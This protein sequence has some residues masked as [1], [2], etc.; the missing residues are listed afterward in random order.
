MTGDLAGAL[1][2]ALEHYFGEPVTVAGLGLLSGGASRETWAFAATKAEG[3]PQRLILKRDPP[4][5]GAAD[6]VGSAFGVDRATEFAVLQ[7]AS[8]AGVP[9]PAGLFATDANSEIGAGMVMAH[10]EGETI[11]RRILRDDRFGQARKLL[12]GQCGAAL[13]AIHTI[14]PEDLPDDLPQFSAVGHLKLFRDL[15]DGFDEP[16]PGFEYG[17]AWLQERLPP[18]APPSLV[19]GDFRNGNVVVDEAGLV[20]VL[21]WELAHLGDGAED[22][23]WL[24]IPSWRYGQFDRAVG[25][26]GDRDELL[27]AYRG[28]GG[29]DVS[30]DELHFWEVLGA[31]RWGLICLT[32]AYSHL[33]GANRSIEMAAIGRRALE[34]EY[35]LLRMVD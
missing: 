1:S 21:D 22:L 2:A 3:T 5:S 24:C 13:A 23:G 26:F 12:T 35:D 17:L 9:S 30:R 14:G 8:A 34:T 29:R 15:L 32:M 27:A 10:V 4:L 7:A 18:P 19:H 28:A 33:R 31:L 20:A 25:G 16:Y 6:P 11:A